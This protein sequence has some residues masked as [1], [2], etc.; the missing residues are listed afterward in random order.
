MPQMMR[1]GVISS[2]LALTLGCGAPGEQ[3]SAPQ[4]NAQP[5]T[6]G[7]A[8]GTPSGAAGSA[9]APAASSAAPAAP[10]PP[11]EPVMMLMDVPSGTELSL[12]LE[13]GVSS[14]TSK[15]DE[16]VRARTLRRAAGA[17]RERPHCDRHDP[18][19]SRHRHSFG[20]NVIATPFIQ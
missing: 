3:A 2:V 15:P 12:I 17:Q 4:G 18:R 16:P 5:A 13:T 1:L 6:P 14:E 7:A 20:S 10:A 8:A 9:D 11:A 19:A